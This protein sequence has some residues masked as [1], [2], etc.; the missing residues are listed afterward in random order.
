MDREDLIV[1]ILKE[2]R[3]DVKEVI[4]SSHVHR[5]ETALWQNNTDHRLENIEVDLREHKEGVINNRHLI[6]VNDEKLETIKALLEA[7]LEELEAGKKAFKTISIKLS[8]IAG[9]CASLFGIFKLV[10]YIVSKFP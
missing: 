9:V 4:E 8:K 6:S 1:A 2:T 7:R 5:Q 10:E 3:D